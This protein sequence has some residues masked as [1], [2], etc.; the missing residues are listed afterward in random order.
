LWISY[1]NPCSPLSFSPLPAP[2]SALQAHVLA[3]SYDNWL[4]YHQY[5]TWDE[6]KEAFRLRYREQDSNAQVYI[7]L[8]TFKQGE[9]EKVQVYYER[10]KKLMKCFQSDVGEGFKLTY[11]RACLSDY[12]Q[13]T[14]SGSI[15]ETLNELKEVAWHYENN[16]IDASRNK[17]I[18]HMKK[19][20]MAPFNKVGISTKIEGLKAA[21]KWYC[22]LRKKFGHDDVNYFNNPTNPNNW[23]SKT[24]AKSIV[25]VNEVLAHSVGGNVKK[26]E[27]GRS[28]GNAHGGAYPKTTG[29]HICQSL[30][31]LME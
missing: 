30:E 27:I 4:D 2:R 16:C 28:R 15:V 25:A 14:T 21:S 17:L 29:C 6:A 18:V 9:S 23:L 8:R 5:C 20:E 19:T 3:S 24:K 7:A 12:L 11:F 31:H 26:H 10:F 1:N 13:I 22:T